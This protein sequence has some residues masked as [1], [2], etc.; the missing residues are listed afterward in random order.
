MCVCVTLHVTRR[1]LCMDAFSVTCGEGATHMKKETL[2][3][4][5][6][7]LVHCKKIYF[8]QQFSQMFI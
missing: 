3:A 1:H 4:H 5:G 8:Q 6:V 7:S 2:L